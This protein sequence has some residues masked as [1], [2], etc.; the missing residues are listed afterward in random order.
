MLEDRY[1]RCKT[2]HEIST[3]LAGC[4]AAGRTC[5][6]ACSITVLLWVGS[7]SRVACYLIAGKCAAGDSG[8]Q[9]QGAGQGGC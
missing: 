1:E 7:A 8:H 6:G 5:C 2:Q 9:G 4:L 3:H